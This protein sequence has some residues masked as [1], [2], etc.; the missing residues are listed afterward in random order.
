MKGRANKDAELENLVTLD[1]AATGRLMDLCQ[2]LRAVDPEGT[3]TLKVD[4]DFLAA[5]LAD[6]GS[7]TRF[8]AE[9]QSGSRGSSR[10]TCLHLTL[11]PSQ[12]GVVRWSN[13]KRS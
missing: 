1:E 3:E 5:I 12:H 7:P 10:A 11:L 9:I 13:S 8:T 4:E 6:P 2:A